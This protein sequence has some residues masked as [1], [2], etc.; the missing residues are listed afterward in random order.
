MPDFLYT[1]DDVIV[2]NWL[3]LK[4]YCIITW[5]ILLILFVDQVGMTDALF[6]SE[7]RYDHWC[8][9]ANVAVDDVTLLNVNNYNTS[10]CE[11]M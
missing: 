8:Y 4:N 5:Q 6:I 9:A 3:V 11:H 7:K 10:L 2:G 1:N